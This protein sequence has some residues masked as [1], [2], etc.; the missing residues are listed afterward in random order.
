MEQVSEC[1]IE[2][3]RVCSSCIRMIH[4]ERLLEINLVHT[5]C[6]VQEGSEVRVTH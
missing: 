1:H 2:E 6:F 3:F 5:P 4:Q